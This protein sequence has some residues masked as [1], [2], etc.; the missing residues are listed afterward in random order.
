M[1]ILSYPLYLHYLGLNGLGLWSVLS[2]LLTFLQLTSCGLA[3]AVTKLV[4]ERLAAGDRVRV[5]SCVSTAA[6]STLV[7]ATFGFCVLCL[8][9]DSVIELLNLEP[10]AAIFARKLVPYT[11]GISVYAL[12]VQVIAAVVPGTGRIDQSNIRDLVCRVLSLAVSIGMLA[13]G[14]GLVGM[15]IGS[16]SYHIAVHITSYRLI[17]NRLGPGIHSLFWS[18]SD[19]VVLMKLGGGIA[20]S[21]LLGFLLQP[22]VK[23]VLSRYVNV[24]SVTIFEICHNSAMQLR[25]VIEAAVR[26][27]MPE[28]S[29]LSALDRTADAAIA[30]RRRT[31]SLVVYA[32][33]LVY[34]IPLLFAPS[35]LEFWLRNR[36]QTELVSSFRIMILASYISLAGVPAYYYLV[37]IGAANRIF[38]ANVL[39]SA[40]NV[41]LLGAAIVLGVRLSVELT[42]LSVLIGMGGGTLALCVAARNVSRLT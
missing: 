12:F 37:G 23:I 13:A 4:A 25:G 9:R 30:L 14:M 26:A 15:L 3:P 24:S 33:A 39:Q 1:M 5:M 22:L 28:V 19:F 10:E 21:S 2:I 27:I 34:S 32:G 18:R 7:F 31:Q 35:L 29:R 38:M 8:T 41:V 20:G 16:L 6:W 17:R 40:V 42:C 11:A 36:Y